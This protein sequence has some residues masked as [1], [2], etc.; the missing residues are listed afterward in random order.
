MD[1]DH[2][3]VLA[4][5]YD[6]VIKYTDADTL[7]HLAGLPIRG[8]LLDAG[9]GTG[10]VAATLKGLA[11]Q[12][13]VADL[14]L[15][16]L[17]R[18]AEKDLQITCG[19]TESLPFPD[20]TFERIIMVDAFHHVYDQQATARELWRVLEPGGMM[21]VVEPDIRLFS[22]RLIAL[23]EKLFFMRSHFMAP[24]SIARFFKTEGA[25]VRLEYNG[26]NGWV[27]ITKEG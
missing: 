11:G 22:V 21:L 18:A 15:G 19:I 20:E 2:F 16:M 14:S 9:G 26:I 6:R 8:C 7:V 12:I 25:S 5:Y 17:R 4:P 27:I 10:R 1:I 24:E 3:G 23:M 13:V